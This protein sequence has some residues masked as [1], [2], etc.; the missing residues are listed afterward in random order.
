MRARSIIHEKSGPDG[1]TR[2]MLMEDN[3]F[4]IICCDCGL[5][6]DLEFKKDKEGIKMRAWRN[7][8]STGQ[9]Q[10]HMKRKK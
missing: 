8:R 2:W 10:R 7:Q 4:R 9:I 5:V 1:W 6:H 3:I